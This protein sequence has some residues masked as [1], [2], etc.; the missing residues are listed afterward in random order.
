MQ[1]GPSPAPTTDPRPR[2]LLVDDDR[3]LCRLMAS[4]LTPLGYE[5][6]AA[7]SGPEA[8]TRIHEPWQAILLDYMLPE[9]DGIEVLRRIRSQ[10]DVPVLMLTARGDEPDRISGL[11]SGA[12]DYLPKTMSTLELVARLRAV[13]RRTRSGPARVA[14]PAET[15]IW[16]IGPL[17]IDHPA[18]TA[19]LCGHPIV[20]TPV[21]YELLLCLAKAAGRVKTREDLLNEIRKRHYEVFDRSIDVHITALRRK[22]GD[23]PKNPRFIRTIRAAG[24]CLISP[25]APLP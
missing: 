1:T 24:Y 21:E 5:V 14:A 9:M 13:L 8:L 16:E 25:D 7:H 22:L 20:L 6:D 3:K 15:G 18:R 10:S 17:R 4:Y 19:T 23:D 2:L 12:D 11:D